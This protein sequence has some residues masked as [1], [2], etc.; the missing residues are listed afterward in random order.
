M[1]SVIIPAYNEEEA[2]EDTVRSVHQVFAELGHAFEIVVIDD[3][4]TDDTRRLL[5]GLRLPSLHVITKT[6][7]G[8]YGAALKTGLRRSRGDL[9][10]I[11]DADGSYPIA[12]FP[13]LLSEMTERGADMVVGARTNHVAI[14]FTRRPAKSIVKLLADTL[15]GMKIPDNNSG[16]RMFTRAL[17][18]R[19]MHLYPRGFSFTVTLTLA[20]LTNDYLVTFVPIDYFNRKG[21]SSLSAGF[22]GIRNFASFLALIVRITTYFRPLKFFVWPGGILLAVGLVTIIWTLIGDANISDAGLLLTLTGI[23]IL[24]FGLLA[25]IVARQRQSS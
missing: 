1:I 8:G 16:M 21:R 11:I 20:A 18:E 22:N 24:L 9:I 17:G 19:F 23:Q 3:A 10:A 5:A 14:P 2:I 13:L 25:D 7:N 12:A 6:R 15:T 4:S